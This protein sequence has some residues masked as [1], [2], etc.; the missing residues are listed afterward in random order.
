VFGR[1]SWHDRNPLK[2]SVC[3][4]EAIAVTGGTGVEP[5]NLLDTLD[6]YQPRIIKGRASGCFMKLYDETDRRCRMLKPGKWRNGAEIRRKALRLAR[7]RMGIT[8]FLAVRPTLPSF[9][10]LGATVR[11]Q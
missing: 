3:G 6:G 2:A 11:L 5:G 7:K 9:T 1:G 4:D 10:A 8:T